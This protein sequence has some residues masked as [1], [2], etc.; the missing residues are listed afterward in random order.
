M[1][2]CLI[3]GGGA[4][5]GGLSKKGEERE[6][7]LEHSG[8]RNRVFTFIFGSTADGK[9]VLRFGEG[10]FSRIKWK[11]KFWQLY[12]VETEVGWYVWESLKGVSR[13][14]RINKGPEQGDIWQDEMSR[15]ASG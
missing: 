10:N 2:A 5:L 4:M 1:V 7:E 14:G 11:L 12:P 6:T 8:F 3:A 13:T 15:M 9:Q